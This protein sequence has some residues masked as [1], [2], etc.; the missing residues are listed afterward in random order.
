MENVK[1]KI[2]NQKSTIKNERRRVS[3]TA[4]SSSPGQAPERALA[5]PSVFIFDF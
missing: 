1:S 2:K 4:A 5:P 3:L